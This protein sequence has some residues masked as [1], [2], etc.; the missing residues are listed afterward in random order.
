MGRRQTNGLLVVG[1]TALIAASPSADAQQRGGGSYPTVIGSTGKP[2]GPTQAEW[3]YRQQYGRPSPGSNGGGMEYVNGYPGGGGGYGGGGRGWGGWGPQLF[4]GFDPFSY[5][6]GQ[7]YIYYPSTATYNNG[8]SYNLNYGAPISP[9]VP[10]LSPAVMQPLPPS[11]PLGGAL[12]GSAARYNQQQIPTMTPADGVDAVIAPSSP[13]AV[14]TSLQY[15]TEGDFQLQMMNYYAAGE[16]YRKAIDAAR[17]RAE[18]RVRLAVTLMARSRFIEAV[19]QLKLATAIDPTYPQVCPSLDDLLGAGGGIE[20][21]RIKERV[22]EWTLQDGRDPNRLFLTGVVLYLDGDPHAKMVIETAIMIAGEQPHLTAF[23][24]QRAVPIP[25][26]AQT[27]AIRQPAAQVGTPALK[28]V[29]EAPKPHVPQVPT[30]PTP[31]AGVSPAAPAV[32]PAPAASPVMSPSPQR[33]TESGPPIPSL[34]PLPPPLPGSEGTG[35]SSS[36][37]TKPTPVPAAPT[38][39]ASTNQPGPA[40]PPLQNP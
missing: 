18:P 33:D 35:A 19:D 39:D 25:Q 24:A 37:G 11:D 29:P 9:V 38:G 3:Q 7:G 16:R 12:G 6:P 15:Q 32:T 36:Q 10:T 1:L 22:A 23:L 40:L 17:D 5:Y 31:P 13:R 34:P 30:L 21:A 27:P 14:E 26:P 28:H 20:K 4:I 8:Y 2:Y